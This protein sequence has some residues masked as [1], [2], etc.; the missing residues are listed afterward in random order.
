MTEPF[1]SGFTSGAAIHVISTQIPSIFG[2]SSPTNLETAFKLPRFYV[3]LI[4]SIIKNINWVSTGIGLT[5]TILLF[6][7]KY[8]NDRYK[9]TVRIVIPNEL[10]LVIIGTIISHFAKIHD[11]HG[12]SVVGN[13]KKGLPPPALPPFKHI[14]YIIVPS[15][16]IAMVSLCIAISMGKVFSRKHNYKVSSNQVENTLVIMKFYLHVLPFI[17]NCWHMECR[18]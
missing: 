8:L 7:A 18:T 9:S 17:R 14:S 10:I 11:Y 5:S 16:T 12:V 4:G 3:K 13:I 6:I 15:I 2:V 1:V